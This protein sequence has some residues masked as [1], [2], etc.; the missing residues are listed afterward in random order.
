MALQDDDE[1]MVQEL[2]KNVVSK[3]CSSSDPDAER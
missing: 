3:S 1:D 2:F